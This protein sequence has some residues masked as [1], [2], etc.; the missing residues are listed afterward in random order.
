MAAPAI[1]AAEARRHETFT[2]L[3]WALSQP[4]QIHRLPASG[5]AAFGAIADALI[6]LE[7]SYYTDHPALGQLLARTGARALPRWLA[8]YQFY[9]EL[10]AATVPALSE[11][12]TGTYS[13]PDESATLIVGCTLG[14]GRPLRLSGP[15][16]ATVTDLWVD[17]IPENFWSLRER[18]CRY[19]LGWD[20]QLVSDDR[21]AGLPRTT[22]VEVE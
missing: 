14:A 11:A 6:D 18:I 8:M 7:T 22:R 12:S 15:G 1:S 16:I 2:A 10:E 9:P 17:R 3:M 13:Y 5:L 19:P 21:V 20:V 4:G